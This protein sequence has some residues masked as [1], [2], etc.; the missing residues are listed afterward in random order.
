MFKENARQNTEIIVK[1]LGL[2]KGIEYFTY[3]YK[4]SSKPWFDK[5]SLNRSNIVMINRSRANHYN[6]AAS[7]ARLKF[8]DDFMHSCGLYEQDL[9]HILWQCQTYDKERVDMIK[10]M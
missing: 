9:D 4:H 6:L 8:I 7:L 3:F 2:K 1:E 10:K 5:K